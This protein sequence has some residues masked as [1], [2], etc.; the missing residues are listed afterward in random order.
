M[1]RPVVGRVRDAAAME[2]A[3]EAGEGGDEAV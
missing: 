3:G 2:E 1:K